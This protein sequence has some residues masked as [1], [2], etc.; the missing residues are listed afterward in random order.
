MVLMSVTQWIMMKYGLDCMHT[1]RI[2][3]QSHLPRDQVLEFLDFLQ[4][5]WM[6][7][8]VFIIEEGLEKRGKVKSIIIITTHL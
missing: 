4:V 7:L 2:F 3:P 1:C 6:F 8:Y 5:L